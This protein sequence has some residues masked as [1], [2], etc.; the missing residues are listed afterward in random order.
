MQIRKIQNRINEIE[1]LKR[2]IKFL[3]EKKKRIISQKL[4]SLKNIINNICE[5]VLQQN[6]RL[7]TLLIK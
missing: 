4:A 6:L 2:N 5:T 1:E 3:L 7:L